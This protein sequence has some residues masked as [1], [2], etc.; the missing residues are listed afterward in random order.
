[1]G[2]VVLDEGHVAEEIARG[3]EQSDPNHRSDNVVSSEGT[4]VHVADAGDKRSEGSYNRYK[5]G[6][7]DGLV[8]V[9]LIKML[10]FLDMLGLDQAVVPGNQFVSELFTDHVV[11]GITKNRRGQADD[12]QRRQMKAARGCRERAAGKQQGVARQKRRDDETGL[13]KN[14]GKKQEI[15]QRAVIFHNNRHITVKVHNVFGKIKKQCLCEIYY[16]IHPISFL[17]GC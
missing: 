2:K 4:V 14:N 8:A 16:C 3:Y 9:F 10:G 7:K 11:A 5:A 1:M 6:E 15:N 12:H 13:T 17:T